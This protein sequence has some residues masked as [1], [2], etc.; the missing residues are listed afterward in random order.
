MLKKQ[1]N[2]EASA[3]SSGATCD[4]MVCLFVSSIPQLTLS[5]DEQDQFT[6]VYIR[7]WQVF[8]CSCGWL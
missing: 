6:D 3:D 7:R 1:V 4:A 8:L 5:W 2:T